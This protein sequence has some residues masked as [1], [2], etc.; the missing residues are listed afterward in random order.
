M[1]WKTL[2]I[3]RRI[4]WV[5]SIILVTC[6]L[7]AM[8]QQAMRTANDQLNEL[9]SHTL[10][11]QLRGLAFEISNQLQPAITGSNFLAHHSGL[12]DWSAEQRSIRN[13]AVAHQALENAMTR[14]G[15][16]NA[17]AVLDS[18]EGKYIFTYDGQ[19]RATR[20]SDYPFKDFYPNFLG[21]N[22]AVELN[23]NQDQVGG[24]YVIFINYRSTQVNPQTNQPY[25]VAGL[26]FNV[27]SLVSMIEGFRIGSNGRAMLASSD[28]KIQVAPKDSV[29]ASHTS[30]QL[31]QA[32]SAGKAA[33]IITELT[34]N[35]HAYLIGSYW[36]ADLDR[37]V[38]VEIPK[39]QII[40]PII[41]QFIQSLLFTLIFIAVA[42]V[43]MHFVV[44]AL[45]KPIQ[46]LSSEIDHIAQHLDLKHKVNIFD[47]TEVANLSQKIN[48]FI[49]RFRDSL[50]SVNQ[51][52]AESQV[53]FLQLKHNA[54]E[55][56]QAT[57]E[58]RSALGTISQASQHITERTEEATRLAN[59]AGELSAQ[60]NSSLQN[61]LSAMHSSLT[62]IEQLGSNMATS[63]QSLQQLNNHIENILRVLE[64]ISSI[65]EQTNLLALN[66]AIEAAR[67]GEHGRGF[68]VVADEVRS[69]SQRTSESTTEIQDII[70]KLRSASNSVTTQIEVVHENSQHSLTT[71]H[72][73]VKDVQAL[74]TTLQALFSMNQ[75]IAQGAEEQSAAVVEINQSIENL[76]EQS[77]RTEQLTQQGEHSVIGVE[78]Q[79]THL[80]AKINQFKGI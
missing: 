65:S 51:T 19:H 60:G 64:V 21:K 68:A 73:A 37:F 39:S 77:S 22:K 43:I 57:E 45:T 5:L 76:N 23:M 55:T 71:H 31:Q 27:S 29:L 16:D 14:L 4:N 69:L 44:T 24:Q 10:P 40:S 18:A 46:Q 54:K 75:Q 48:L 20:L 63:Q 8:G 47:G 26:G 33:P 11:S 79:M 78:K 6:T 36:L 80:A 3:R 15:A 49:E 56:N 74:N 50:S 17:F 30:G 9:K 25:V 38:V 1:Y 42:L 59:H 2:S 35:Q 34:V 41:D 66:A 61:A 32:I 28:G 58:Q 70:N 12:L 67:A 53:A 52:V 7:I 62:H 72:Q 13:P